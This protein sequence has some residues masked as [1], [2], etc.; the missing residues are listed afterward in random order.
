MDLGRQA[1]AGRCSSS[2]AGMLQLGSAG[3]VSSAVRVS[4]IIPSSHPSK[5][6]GMHIPQIFTVPVL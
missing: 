6:G 4:Q 5:D 2:Q 3:P 1:P